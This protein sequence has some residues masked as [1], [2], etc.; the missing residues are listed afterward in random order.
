MFSYLSD[1][2]SIFSMD[3]SDA[4]PFCQEGKDLIELEEKDTGTVKLQCHCFYTVFKILP[5]CLNTNQTLLFNSGVKFN[6][7]L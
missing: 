4:S 6:P 2:L 1:D 5:C 3:L 7:K